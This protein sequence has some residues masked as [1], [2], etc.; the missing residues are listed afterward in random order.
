MA[1]LSLSTPEPSRTTA[2]GNAG[3]GIVSL[4]VSVIGAVISAALLGV[5]VLSQITF[6]AGTPDFVSATV[7]GCLS[8]LLAAGAGLALFGFTAT[9]TPASAPVALLASATVRMLVSLSIALAIYFLSRPPA[10]TGTVFWIIFLLCGLAAIVAE[11]A[12]GVKNLNKSVQPITP[13][14]PAAHT[15]APEAH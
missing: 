9:R 3:S 15:L 6:A 2:T 10:A 4:T 12:W 14:A 8:V 7:Q 1:P 13:A 11:T 5:G